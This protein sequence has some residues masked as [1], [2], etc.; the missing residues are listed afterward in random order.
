VLFCNLDETIQH[1]FFY[2]SFAKFIWRIVGITFGIHTPTS[3]LDIY[4]H[5]LNIYSANINFQVMGYDWSRRHMLGDMVK[6]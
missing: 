2:C 1:L 6:P 5:S 4:V 3:I